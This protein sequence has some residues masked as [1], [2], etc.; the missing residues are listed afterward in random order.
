MIALDVQKALRDAGARMVGAG[1]VESALCTTEHPALSGAVVDP[2]A[3]SGWRHDSVSG[4]LRQL[5]VPFVVYTGYPP[6]PTMCPSRS[7]PANRQNPPADVMMSA[8]RAPSRAL[9]D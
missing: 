8:M 7:T 1:M 3:L 4:G 6:L 5:G 2:T 9:A